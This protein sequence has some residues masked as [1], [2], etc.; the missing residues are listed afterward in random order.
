MTHATDSVNQTVILL[1]LMNDHEGLIIFTTNFIENY[2]PAFMRRILAHIHLNYLDD[3]VEKNYGS[4]IFND[5]T[6]SS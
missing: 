3:S 2:D 5:S 6:T 1:T 4:N